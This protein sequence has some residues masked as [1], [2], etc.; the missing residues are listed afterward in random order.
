[1]AY[2]EY[3]PDGAVDTLVPLVYQ[4]AASQTVYPGYAVKFSNGKVTPISAQTDVSIGIILGTA[5]TPDEVSP[6]VP[7]VPSTPDLTSTSPVAIT[8]TSTSVVF[9]RV[10]PSNLGLTKF[11]IGFTPLVDDVAAESNSTITQSKVALT[12]G[13]SSDLVGG[14]VYCKE[15]GEAKLITANTYSSNVVTLTHAAFSRIV[16]TGDTLR[17]IPFGPGDTAVKFLA[18]TYHGISNAIADLSS[19]K[20]TVHRVNLPKKYAIVSFNAS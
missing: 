10:I 4:L 20:L 7:S 15:L 12:D 2:F 6:S 8:T 16:T 9:V 13:S 11:R 14:Y 18:S 19:G 5:N 1:M 17:V 3:F